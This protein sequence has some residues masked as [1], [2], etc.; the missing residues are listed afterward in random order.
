M[1]SEFSE[2]REAYL[3]IPSLRVLILVEQDEPA[4]AVHRR[5]ADGGFLREDYAGLDAVV[6]LPEIESELP[7]AEVFEGVEF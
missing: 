2:K 5:S 3:A 7:L 1:P 4:L 6:P